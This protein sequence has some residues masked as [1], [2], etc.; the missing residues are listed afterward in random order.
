MYFPD[1]IGRLDDAD[2]SALE[3]ELNALTIQENGE[4]LS[5]TAHRDSRSNYNICIHI[6]V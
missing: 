4:F 2:M 1:V 5:P 3:Q 6:C